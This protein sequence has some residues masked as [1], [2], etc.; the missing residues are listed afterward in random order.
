MCF[1][2]WQ[3]CEH[4]QQNVGQPHKDDRLD[5]CFHVQY[6]RRVEIHVGNGFDGY[7]DDH[8]RRDDGYNHNP[9]DIGR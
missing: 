4:D 5:D 7:D 2:R 6:R 9:N 1:P 3:L 8:D